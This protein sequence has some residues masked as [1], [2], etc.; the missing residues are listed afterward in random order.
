[1]STVSIEHEKNNMSALVVIGSDT[2]HADGVVGTV[3]GD[4]ETL[5]VSSMDYKNQVGLLVDSDT[6]YTEIVFIGNG[7]RLAEYFLDFGT[8]EGIMATGCTVNIVASG[9]H[10]NSALFRLF[11]KRVSIIK[12]VVNFSNGDIGGR[13]I[14]SVWHL[15]RQCVYNLEGVSFTELLKNENIKEILDTDRLERTN[16][17]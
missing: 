9:I 5:V 15:G 11:C 16:H 3:I 4:R 13:T 6:R 10:E 12:G 7:P 8:W 14:N 17:M 1:M 2:K